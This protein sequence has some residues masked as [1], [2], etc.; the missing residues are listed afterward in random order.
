MNLFQFL[1]KPIQIGSLKLKH[2]MVM[3]PMWTRYCT[4]DGAVTPQ[5]IDYY[6]AR[7]RG[8]A[9]LIV[10]E[11]TTVDR[12]Y[13]WSEA[14][15]RL[16]G[17]ELQPRFHSLV[18]AIH[19]NGAAAIVQLIHVG[20][21]SD[22]PIS[23]SGVPS[24]KLGGSGIFKPRVMSLEEIEETREKFISAAVRAKEA[25]CDGVLVHGNTAY[26]LHHFVSPY[27]NKRTDKY[28]GNMENRFRLPLEIVRGIRQKCGPEFCLGYELVCDELLPGGITYEQSIPFAKSLEREGV[29]F[30]DIAIGTYETFASTDRSPGQSKYTRFGEWEHTEV[31]KKEVKVPIVHRAHGDYDPFSWEKHLQAG[32]ADFIQVAKPSLCDPELFKKVL[33]G[34]IE[35]IRGCTTCTHCLDAGV[36]G[37]QLVEC[38]LNPECGKE[39]DYA[40]QRVSN[41]K[42]VLVIGS[43]PGGLEAARVAALRG[44]E[45]NLMEKG[46]ELGGK[47]RYLALCYDNEPSGAF[48]DWEV[49]QCK[50]AGVKFELNKEATPDAIQEAKPDVV[51]VATGAPKHI[52]PN[53]PGISKSHVI[54]PEDVLTGKASVGKKVVVIGG[55]RIGVDIAYTIMKRRLAEAVIII[56]QQSV[57]SVGYDMEV[58]NMAMMTMCLLSKL[59]VRALTDTR[60]EEITDNSVR[61]IDPEGKK[62]K[63]EADTVVLSAGYTPDSTL[64]EA[65]QG[66]VKELYAIGDCVKTRKIRDAVHEAAFVARQI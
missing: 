66:K 31:F 60:V 5:M 28:G 3:G 63:I 55:N 38:A 52:I 13:G 50:N 61:V 2:R 21:F 44:H 51:I 42:R 22:N 30:L 45:V 47:L 10:I 17:Q 15:L 56:E 41:P 39:R 57:P 9:S 7:A 11:S 59:G 23:P 53:I 27:T 49:R 34:R 37:H 35:D 20:A 26:L 32:N 54:T 18:E 65:L 8:G 36:I 1:A 29:D 46:A 43:G 62:Q 4:L 24:I 14:T 6:S 19:F 64:Y 40:I 33:E 48:R 12:R 58:M 16:D 25:G